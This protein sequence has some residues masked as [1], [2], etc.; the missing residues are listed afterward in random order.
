M[1]R[2]ILLAVALQLW[3][4]FSP[5]TLAAA[6]AA[7]AL[8]KGSGAKL[9][10]PCVYEYGHLDIDGIAPQELGRYRETQMQRIDALVEQRLKAFLDAVPISD[11]PIPSLLK[12]GESRQ[13][14]VQTTET[15]A[16]GVS[17]MCSLAGWPLIGVIMPPPWWSWCSGDIGAT[18]QRGMRYTPP[19]FASGRLAAIGLTWQNGDGWERAMGRLKERSPF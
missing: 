12:G 5:H 14:I 7:I 18:P 10:A 8:A 17:W 15:L 3:Q 13:Q 4:E 6:D 11:L 1:D 2:H 9:S 16:S 19:F